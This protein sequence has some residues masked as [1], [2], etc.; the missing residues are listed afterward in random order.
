M[1][2]NMATGKLIPARFWFAEDGSN[3]VDCP[4]N[5]PFVSQRTWETCGRKRR[6][7]GFSF[8]LSFPCGHESYCKDCKK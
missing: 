2:R 7:R 4:P 5:K 8:R 1:N 3:I 6:V